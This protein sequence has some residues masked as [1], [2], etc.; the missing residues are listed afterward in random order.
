VRRDEGQED[1][2]GQ[3][4]EDTCEK[5]RVMLEKVRAK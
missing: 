2:E 5:V 3:L 4:R 1:G